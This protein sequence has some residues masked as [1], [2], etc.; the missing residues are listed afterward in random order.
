M[1]LSLSS[2]RAIF[3]YCTGSSLLRR[4]FHQTRAVVLVIAVNLDIL[5]LRESFSYQTSAYLVVGL[6]HLYFAPSFYHVFLAH[7]YEIDSS[8][9]HESNPFVVIHDETDIQ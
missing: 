9:H 2:F 4:F 7:I 6:K 3:V 1:M 8:T 5:L